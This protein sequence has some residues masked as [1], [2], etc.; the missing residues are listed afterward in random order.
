VGAPLMPDPAYR[1]PSFV[2]ALVIIDG[3]YPKILRIIR[4][5]MRLEI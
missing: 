3:H 4:T 2:Y 5:K 1:L